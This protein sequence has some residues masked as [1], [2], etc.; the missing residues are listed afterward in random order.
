MTKTD[1]LRVSSPL[2]KA[3]CTRDDGIRAIKPIFS[4]PCLFCPLRANPRCAALFHKK[5]T[6][7]SSLNR[8]CLRLGA[9]NES[10]PGLLRRHGRPQD[11]PN[12]QAGFTRSSEDLTPPVVQCKA[13]CST[14]TQQ[15]RYICSLHYCR[16]PRG[17]LPRLW[18]IVVVDAAAGV[19]TPLPAARRG[20]G[21]G[22]TIFALYGSQF[23][24]SA[25]SIRNLLKAV[26]SP[27]WHRPRPWRSDEE[28]EMIR[29]YAFW[30]FRSRD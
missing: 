9:R 17:R 26:S 14:K 24:C 23:G 8:Q 3:G 6:E 28:A 20:N 2:T 22:G 1:L 15:G 27:N 21:F 29:R 12:S 13:L 11:G 25:S 30:W 4:V 16:C 19:R 10:S 7:S 18:L 5:A